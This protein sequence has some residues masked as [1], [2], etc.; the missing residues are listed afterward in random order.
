MLSLEPFSTVRAHFKGNL[1]THSTISDGR[2]TPQEVVKLYQARGYDFLAFTDH[3]IFS[4][5][6]EFD[7]T[8]FLILP[9]IEG[10]GNAPGPYQC[11]H[12]VGIGDAEIDKDH[13]QK[14][15]N[16]GLQGLAGAQTM[17]DYFEEQGYYSIYCHPVWSRQTF[18][19]VADL[20]RF[21]AIEVYNHGCHLENNTGHASYYWDG[22]L[23]QGKAFG[24]W[25]LTTPTR[26]WKIMVVAG[27][28]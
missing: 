26:I 7:Q 20:E 18:A 28:W 16:S 8:D 15:D 14:L 19:E 24:V 9:G 10:S 3:E 21:Q 4:W 1:H 6:D 23:R 22:F 11:H 12:V 17:V 27:W 25:Q 5:W 2:L 13:L